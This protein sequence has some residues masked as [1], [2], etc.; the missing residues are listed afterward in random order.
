MVF[1]TPDSRVLFLFIILLEDFGYMA[2]AGAFLMDKV[3][4]GAGLHGRA[5]H[6]SA[7]ELCLRHPR[8]HGDAA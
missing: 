4:G 5:F 3:M 2:R 7:I 1:P 8:D 6:S